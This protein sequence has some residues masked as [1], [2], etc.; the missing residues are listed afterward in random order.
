MVER[1]KTPRMGGG[2]G[3]TTYTG[4]HGEQRTPP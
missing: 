2:A 1:D 3:A 4:D